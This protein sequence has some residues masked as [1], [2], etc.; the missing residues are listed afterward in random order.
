MVVAYLVIGS[1][2]TISAFLIGLM[3]DLS[4]WGALGVGYM[5]G[6]ISV[7]VLAIVAYVRYG[8][9]DTDLDVRQILRAM[10]FKVSG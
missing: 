10:S 9:D 4:F 8:Q 1:F 2:F 3:C 7:V 5:S 6:L